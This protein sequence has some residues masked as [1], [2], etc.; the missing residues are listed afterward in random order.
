MYPYIYSFHMQHNIFGST[1]NVVLFPLSFDEVFLNIFQLCRPRQQY[2]TKSAILSL[3]LVKA[4]TIQ[5]DGTPKDDVSELL[6]PFPY[7]SPNDN[8][9][10]TE[11]VS[12]LVYLKVI[13]ILENSHFD[14]ILDFIFSARY[15]FG[16]I[17]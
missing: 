13:Y 3:G 6:P 5:L 11:G 2:S 7:C 8:N 17:R 4:H 9:M 1:L 14:H 16:R 12:K 15:R 10:G